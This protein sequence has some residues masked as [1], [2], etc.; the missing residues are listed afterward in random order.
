LEMDLVGVCGFGIWPRVWSA[1]EHRGLGVAMSPSLRL[2]RPRFASL[3]VL[4]SLSVLDVST[5]VVFSDRCS[6]FCVPQT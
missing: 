2:A 3:R 4:E 5:G 1:G 6:L